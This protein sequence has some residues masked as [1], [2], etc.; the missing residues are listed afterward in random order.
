M[1]VETSENT[2]PWGVLSEMS[3]RAH[4]I[5]RGYCEAAVVNHFEVY[6]GQRFGVNIN[7]LFGNEK[8]SG[9]AWRNVG[10]MVG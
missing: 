5:P 8:R 10:G 1:H 2:P 6:E 9:M 7:H 4:P 3:S